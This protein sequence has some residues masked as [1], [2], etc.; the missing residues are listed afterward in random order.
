MTQSSGRQKFGTF[1]RTAEP[2]AGEEKEQVKVTLNGMLKR[3]GGIE[4]VVPPSKC[5]KGE[6]G[7]MSATRRRAFLVWELPSFMT[8]H[9]PKRS[10]R[11][12]DGQTASQLQ[13]GR[14]FAP[15]E[16]GK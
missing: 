3:Y 8:E 7:L 14:A 11:Y 12:S 6:S 13:V 9:P 16:G 1:V 2:E 10:A 15:E 4:E 5:D